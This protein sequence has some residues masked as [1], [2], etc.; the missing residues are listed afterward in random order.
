MVEDTQD[1]N[2]QKKLLDYQNRLGGKIVPLYVRFFA[3]A[4]DSII[5]LVIA[6][7]I[8]FQFD[9]E[10]NGL[11][12]ILIVSGLGMV[13][14]TIFLSS[15]LKATPGKLL[16][17]IAVVNSRGGKLN[18]IRSFYRFICRYFSIYIF[19]IGVLYAFGDN[20]KR[21]FHCNISRSYVIFPYSMNDGDP[22]ILDENL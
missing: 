20:F 7:I 11:S 9:E 8:F 16:L 15:K 12:P 18:L 5:K 22:L 10:F 2:S 19:G 13:Y 14:E 21:T 3:F 4:I 1:P 17:G 6:F